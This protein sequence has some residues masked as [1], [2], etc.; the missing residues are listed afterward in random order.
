MR[1]SLLLLAPALAALAACNPVKPV[2][3]NLRTRVCGGQ[4]PIQDAKALRFTVFGDG[5]SPLENRKTSNLDAAS[6]ELPPVTPGEDRS[7]LV[8]ALTSG[9]ASGIVRARGSTLP[10]DLATSKD[11]LSVAVF[12]R[13][14]DAF[15]PT[16]DANDACTSMATPRAAHTATTLGDGRVLIAGGY[17]VDAAGTA[18]LKSTEIY[19]PSTGTFAPGPDMRLSRAYHTATHVPRTNYTLIVGGENEGVNKPGGALKVAELFDESTNTFTIVQMRSART[20]HA[21]A[22]SPDGSGVFVVGGKSAADSPLTSTEIF[23]PQFK[24]FEEG[25]ALAGPRSEGTAVALPGR[26]VLVV[27]GFDGTSVVSRTELFVQRPGATTFDAVAGWNVS[28]TGANGLLLGAIRPAAAL[29]GTSQVV[30]T[31]GY[32]RRDAGGGFPQQ[33]ASDTTFVVD[34][35]EDAAQP[36]RATKLNLGL[37]RANAGAVSLLDGRVLVAGGG[38]SE[39]NTVK[40][41]NTADLFIANDAQVTGAATEFPMMEARYLAAYTVLLDGTVLATGGVSVDSTTQ[42]FLASAEVYQPPYAA[43]ET[44]FR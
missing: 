30:V 23:N 10:L 12:L 43:G 3:I 5:L 20:R 2:A 18:Y 22:A 38:F 14:L 9:D 15:T 31:G 19:D 27:G 8:E 42:K 4:D 13:R 21:A 41:R 11:E 26:R 24:T 44:P 40:T 35:P 39:A 28:L 7:V 32:T 17:V 37:K 29:F 1:K 33:S 6:S 34:V 16:Q 25:P 36:G